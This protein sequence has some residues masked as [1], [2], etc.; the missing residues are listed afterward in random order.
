MLKTYSP[1]LNHYSCNDKSKSGNTLDF[2]LS[3][4]ECNGLE[5]RGVHYK[6]NHTKAQTMFVATDQEADKEMY[7]NAYQR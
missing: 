6:Y 2:D 5:T 7:I 3:L 1:F 4:Q